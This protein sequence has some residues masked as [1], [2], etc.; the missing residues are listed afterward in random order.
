MSRWS[1]WRSEKRWG[2]KINKVPG[3]KKVGGWIQLRQLE[4]REDIGKEWRDDMQ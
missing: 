3:G 4:K 2:K 1:S